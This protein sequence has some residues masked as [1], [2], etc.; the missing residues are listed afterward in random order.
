M[1]TVGANGVGRVNIEFEI[2]NY[3][4]LVL[5]RRGNLPP[6]KVRRQTIQGIVDPGATTLVLPESV[7]KRLGLP[8]GDTTQVTY[9]DGRTAQRDQ[10]EGAYVEILG[11][12]GTF[13]A[14]VEPRRRLA[15]IGAVV[16]EVLDLLVDCRKGRLIPR[17]PRGIMYEIE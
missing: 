9:A 2:T 12:H 5:V 8:P 1:R 17:D 10:A 13:T 4:D 11:R 15:L 3:D 7:V 16:L 14:L 6:E